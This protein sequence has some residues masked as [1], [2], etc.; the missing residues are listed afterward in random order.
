MTITEL[1]L[2]TVVQFGQNPKQSVECP[3]ETR[4]D[5]TSRILVMAGNSLDIKSYWTIR[6]FNQDGKLYIKLDADNPFKV[7]DMIG[8]IYTL[9]Q[10]LSSWKVESA[11][12]LPDDPELKKVIPSCL[13]NIKI[14]SIE[15]NFNKR[16]LDF[17]FFEAILKE[18]KCFTVFDTCYLLK[19]YNRIYLIGRKSVVDDVLSKIRQLVLVSAMM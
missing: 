3:N 7:S 19:S 14:V 10:T 2:N 6:T 5:L 12:D 9:A 11:K 18:R 17:E 4:R 13:N 16:F 8:S 15:S 1:A